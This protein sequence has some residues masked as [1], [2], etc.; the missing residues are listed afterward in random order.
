MWKI[1]KEPAV[2]Y[3]LIIKYIIS[4]THDKVNKILIKV[5]INFVNKIFIKHVRKLKTSLCAT[6]TNKL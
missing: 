3:K 1:C 2:G 5:K 6:L 4:Q